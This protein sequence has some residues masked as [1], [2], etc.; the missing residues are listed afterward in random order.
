V[1]DLDVILFLNQIWIGSADILL[2]SSQLSVSFGTAGYCIDKSFSN[3]LR[4]FIVFIV[5]MCL[6]KC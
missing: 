5:E 4:W 6:F 1:V 2:T 3:P